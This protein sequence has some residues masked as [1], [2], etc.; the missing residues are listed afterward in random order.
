MSNKTNRLV[1][2]FTAAALSL[3]AGCSSAQ[4]AGNTTVQDDDCL[5]ENNDGYCDDDGSRVGSS[6]FYKNG[7][8][9][10]KKMHSGVSTSS[11]GVSSGSSYTN[12]SSSGSSNSAGI[13]NGTPASG[14][15]GGIGSSGGSSTS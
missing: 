3:T 10:F 12:P 7:K 9:Y 5:D 13:P 1:G 8:K 2:L 15:K 11:S 4:P 14:S 6:Y